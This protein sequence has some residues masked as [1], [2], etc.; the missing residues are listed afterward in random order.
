VDELVS[1][2]GVTIV[3]CWTYLALLI[4]TSLF[5]SQCTHSTASMYSCKYKT[6]ISRSVY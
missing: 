5:S 1:N 2:T 3:Q 6:F 4:S